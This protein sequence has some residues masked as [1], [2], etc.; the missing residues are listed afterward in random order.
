MVEIPFCNF[1]EP[2][3]PNPAEEFTTLFRHLF[4]IIQFRL[5]RS[6]K[7]HA[8]VVKSKWIFFVIC[9]VCTYY[10]HQGRCIMPGVCL[11][12]CLFVCLLATLRNNYWTDLH[13]NFT[14]DASV[15]KKELINWL[16]DIHCVSK[17]GPTCKLSVTLSNLNRFSKFLHYWKAYK[18]R[19][20]IDTK[21]PTSP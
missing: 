3:S 19:Y 15:H 14:T 12:V 10:V 11:A 7:L 8:T 9:A 2:T 13:E 6:E 5:C 4:A 17:K 20:K 21:L 1:G 18:I 16:N